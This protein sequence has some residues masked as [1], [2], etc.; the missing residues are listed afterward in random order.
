MKIIDVIGGI[1]NKKE[2]DFHYRN[3]TSYK[4]MKVAYN[5]ALNEEV[6]ISDYE[7]GKAI[8]T[9]NNDKYCKKLGFPARLKHYEWAI[10]KALKQGKILKVRG[11][12]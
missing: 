12:R 3:A 10:A 2:K 7:I 1:K 5:S 9:V 11:L 8:E 6:E 4:D